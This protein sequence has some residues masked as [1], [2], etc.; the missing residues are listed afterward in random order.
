MI[1]GLVARNDINE[2]VEL[3]GKLAD[4]LTERN[5]DIILD[6][7]LARELDRYQ[8]KGCELED[9]DADLVVAVGGDGTILRTQ[10]F[11][12]H[13]KIPL[14]G[15]NMG[16]VGFLTEIDPENAF[17][18]LEEILAGNYSVERRNQLLVWHKHEL[19]PA[20]NEVVLMTRKPAKMLHIQISVDDEIV[21]ELRAD[22][23]IIATPSGSTAYS[24]SAGGPIIDPRVEAFI[25]VPICPFK[26]GARPTVVADES[27]IKVKLLREGKKAIAVIDGQFE[28][29]INYMDEIIFRKSENC[30]YFVRLTKDFYRK[31]REK[32][33]KGGID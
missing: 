11:I 9:M 3:A 5:V 6:A 23:L 16:T 14:I 31:V 33:T 7:P 22:G 27:I 13:K 12:S 10:S 4:F 2:A 1:M 20:L 26:L 24:M 25:I 21:E 17:S 29:E 15:I 30:A 32:L 28:E 19:P 8:D 18:A